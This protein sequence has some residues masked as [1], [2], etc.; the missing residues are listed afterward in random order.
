MAR[1]YIVVAPTCLSVPLGNCRLRLLDES[2]I[3]WGDS[4]SFEPGVAR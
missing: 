3:V 2:S 4:D 1:Q